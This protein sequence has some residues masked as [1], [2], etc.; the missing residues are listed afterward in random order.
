MSLTEKEIAMPM[1]V[2]KAIK[3]FRNELLDLACL[4]LPAEKNRV[5]RNQAMEKGAVCEQA[6]FEVLEDIGLVEKCIA[7][8]D[9]GECTAC[10]NLGYIT[11]RL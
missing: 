8:P 9:E 11:R 5:F 4:G 6:V 7:C 3:G 2:A 10:Q 1:R